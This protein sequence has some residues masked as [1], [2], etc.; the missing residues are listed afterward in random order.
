MNDAEIDDRLSELGIE[1]PPPPAALA[2]YLPVRIVGTTAYVAGQVPS[3]EG[4]PMSPGRLGDTVSLE[5]G[6]LAAR[7]G[8]IQALAALKEALGGWGRLAGIAQVTVFIA[9][10][11]E[12]TGHPQVANGASDLLVEVL[13][14]DGRHARAAVG[15]SSL[16]LGASVEVQVTAHLREA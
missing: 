10:T 14:E 9:S 1:L 16:P 3:A 15:M 2:S 5:E 8:A 6:A 11:P 13:G 12:F 4:S 7:R